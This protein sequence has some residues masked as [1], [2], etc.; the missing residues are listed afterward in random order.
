M[1]LTLADVPV[2][3]LL[4]DALSPMT[5]VGAR[6]LRSLGVRG[7]LGYLGPTTR[8]ALEAGLSEGLGFMPVSECRH[9]PGWVP[10]ATLG[11][12]DG[13]LARRQARELGLPPGGSTWCD[14][15][16]MAPNTVVGTTAYGQ[17]WVLAAEPDGDVPGAYVGAGVELSPEQLYLWPFRGYW[18]SCSI[19]P[20]VAVVDYQMLQ[21]YPPDVRELFG[22]NL[23]FEVDLDV[24]QEDKKGRVPRWV[25]AAP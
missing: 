8:A 16:A 24:C 1:Q 21:L 6:I 20:N 11:A 23:P 18:R 15:A 19:V 2:G 5:P 7:W 22:E 12:V 4:V 13:A 25:V 17:A 9:A 14:L 3:A 10:S